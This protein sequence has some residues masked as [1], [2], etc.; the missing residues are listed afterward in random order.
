[1][2]NKPNAFYT[3]QRFVKTF[4]QHRELVGEGIWL[5]VKV[6][7]LPI[8]LWPIRPDRM[9][10][11][12][13][14]T[15]FLAGWIYHSPG[16]ERVPLL[17]DEVIQVQQAPCPWD[18]YHGMGA[19]Q[20]IL[21]DLHS[22]AAAAEWNRN[23][24]RNSAEPGGIIQVDRRLDDEQFEE[25]KLRWNE[26]H[27]GV[28][29]AHRVAILETAEWV[30]NA[31]SMRDMQFVELRAA[32]AQQIREA[33]AFPKTML[34]DIA[35]VNRASAEAEH[36]IWTSDHIVP[37]AD[38]IQGELNG[39]LVPMYGSGPGQ[40]AE[41]NYVSPVPED[42]EAD[43]RTRTSR[44]GAA[45]I[46]A[47]AGWDPDG[48]LKWAGIPPMSWKAPAFKVK[49]PV[50]EPTTARWTRPVWASRVVEGV[51]ADAG[52]ELPD[53][54]QPAA[55]TAASPPENPDL[56]GVREDV[57]TATASLEADYQ[58]TVDKQTDDLAAQAQKAVDD[59]VDTEADDG[60][61]VAVLAA[62]ALLAVPV[63]LLGL[64]TLTAA[65]GTMATAAARRAISEVADAGVTVTLAVVQKTIDLS[66]DVLNAAA[67]ATARLVAD[68]LAGSAAREAVRLWT[69]GTSG[70]DLGDLVSIHLTSLTGAD[71]QAQF[72]GL[73]HRATNLGRGATFQAADEAKPDM[74]IYASETNDTNRCEPCTEF[75]GHQFATLAEAQDTYV[76]GYPDCEGGIR[77]RG[78][79]RVEWD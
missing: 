41:F 15:Q 68:A 51:I 9:E 5:V 11:V 59:N 58:P 24:F 50:S 63:S 43:D 69:P 44:A 60:G 8:E 26:Q 18:P 14:P 30:N 70:K 71:R 33:F 28:N 17:P 77:C 20:T 61:A 42:K 75:D 12:P 48:A 29:N 54:A 74:K 37:R 19:V 53:W 3:R 49:T 72:G 2:W 67:E 23:F 13:H 10:P 57:D 32:S 1:V 21:T 38:D 4:Q 36:Y 27:R 25:M 64:A 65:A 56:A 79:F 7:S 45:A 76:F 78:T 47:G 22:A 46:L 6:G 35:D 34:G 16:G 40:D 31:F 73:L 55:I 66:I 52:W 39:R 62:L